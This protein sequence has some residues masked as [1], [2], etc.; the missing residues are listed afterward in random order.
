MPAAVIFSFAAGGRLAMAEDV[1]SDGAEAEEAAPVGLA[2]WL[3]S[4]ACLPQAATVRT[5]TS[6][7]S[8]ARNR[9]DS[10]LR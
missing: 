10:R 5:V 3:L 6:P 7:T 4:P 2:G 1:G 9:F 8:S